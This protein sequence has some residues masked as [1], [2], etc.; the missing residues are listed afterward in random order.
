M[1]IPVLAAALLL[2][3]GCS[4]PGDEASAPSSLTPIPSRSTSAAPSSPATTTTT[5]P[6]PTAAPTPGAPMPGVTRWVEAGTVGDASDFHRATRDGVTTELGE[7]V[8]FVTPSGKTQ[9]MTDENSDGALACLV[10]L[11][12]PPPRPAEAYGEW[13]GGWVDFDGAAVEVGAVRADPGQFSAGTGAELPYGSTLKFGDYQC[14]S[15]PDGL[16][17]VNFAHR[18]AV[19]LSDAGVQPFGCLRPVE[20]PK[21]VGA[22]YACE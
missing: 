14:R 22:R 12:D 9:C 18:T 15:D 2:L 19:A 7:H 8:A 17:C 4:S 5:S 20:P 21:F 13:I 16:F 6:V 10:S 1:R 11:T 3:A